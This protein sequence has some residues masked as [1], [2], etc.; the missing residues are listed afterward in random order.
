M[1]IP[2]PPGSI[3]TLVNAQDY[4]YQYWNPGSSGEQSDYGAN[5]ISWRRDYLK[6]G[7]IT[8]PGGGKFRTST[9]YEIRSARLA[10]MKPCIIE[11]F[12]YPGR[13][14]WSYVKAVDTRY[15]GWFFWLEG[16][17]LK[18]QDLPLN[19][20]NQ[21]VTKAMNKLADAKA[22]MGENLG[23][24]GQTISM[25][26]SKGKILCD[27]FSSVRKN[28]SLLPFLNKSIDDIKRLGIDNVAAS[29]YI[30]Y[31]YGLK[32][33]MSDVYTLYKEAVKQS[34]QPLLL[35]TVG[36][37][38][39]TYE[40]PWGDT[41]ISSNAQSFPKKSVCNSHVKATIWARID[42]DGSHVRA[43]N[44]LGLLN[45]LT[46]AYNLTPWSFLVDWFLP[47]GQVLS[48]LTAPAGLIFVDGSIS[49]KHKQT[50]VRSY[51]TYHA[52]NPNILYRD[53]YVEGEYTTDKE[54]YYREP[55]SGWPMPGLY[56]DKDPF[57]A[58]RPLK[59][60]ALSILNLGSLRRSI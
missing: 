25:F 31:I 5:E 9:P 54:V 3:G 18:V 22:D 17:R 47:I 49:A 21:A 30:E 39:A 45:P 51:I 34:S 56:I 1:A 53:N 41:Y 13:P 58:D 55:L 16:T 19:M 57:R 48:A 7:F 4:K 37:S 10:G 24:L 32:P 46:L 33:L 26:T 35:K 59:A 12:T 43:L 44:Q 29:L 20:K 8:L 2:R 52:A 38:S 36:T 42:P 11:G 23:T 15:V 27:A 28:K 14:P 60:L 40:A 50:D 6:G